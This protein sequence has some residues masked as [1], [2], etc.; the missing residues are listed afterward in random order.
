MLDHAERIRALRSKFEE[1]EREVRS[2]LEPRTAPRPLP[3]P[4]SPQPRLPEQG[5]RALWTRLFGGR[6]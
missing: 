2:R 4:L 3:E 6:E 5:L 1:L